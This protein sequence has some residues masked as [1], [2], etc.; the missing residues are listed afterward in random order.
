[1]KY[2]EIVEKFNQTRTQIQGL[3]VEYKEK[4][5]GQAY[6]KRKVQ[7]ITKLDDLKRKAKAI[8]TNGNI[9]H[10]QGKRSRPH[11]KNPKIMIQERF[12][13]YFT[14]I[15]EQE[16]SALVKLHVQNVV[17]YTITFIRP[18]VIITTS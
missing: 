6:Q 5:K 14:N 7:L 8:G 11:R 4:I 15:T 9:C 1:M 12:N 18:G 16:A 2:F 13:L 17:H 3:E 10:I